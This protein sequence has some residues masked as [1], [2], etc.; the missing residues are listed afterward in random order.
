MGRNQGHQKRE[1][2]DED[3]EEADQAAT[4]ATK[5]VPAA[6]AAAPV[7]DQRALIPSLE[8]LSAQSA[9]EREGERRKVEQRA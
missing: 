9:R 5:F 3:E 6:A 2:R 4:M 1:P 7:L 8:P